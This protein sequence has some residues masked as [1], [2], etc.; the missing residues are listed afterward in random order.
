MALKKLSFKV[1]DLVKPLLFLAGRSR[2]KR[3]SKSDSMVIRIPLRLWATLFRDIIKS[4]RHNILSQ[5]YPEYLGLLDRDDI[6]SGGEDLFGRRFLKHLVEEAKSQATLEGISKK[7]ATPSKDQQAA[8]T[9]QRRSTNHFNSAPRAG[10][11][12]FSPIS[13]GGQISR[14]VKAWQKITCDPWVLGTVQYGLSLDFVSPPFQQKIP[15]NAAMN[16]EQTK[17]CQEEVTSLLGKGVITQVNDYG[18]V[19]GFFL[20]PKASGGMAYN[21]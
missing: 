11:V 2:L 13:F 17:I 6:W 21:H 9:S 5:V 18:F 16:V 1:L 14:Y 10:Y 12:T 20:V 7:K 19:S 4:R 15:R 8:S 3:K